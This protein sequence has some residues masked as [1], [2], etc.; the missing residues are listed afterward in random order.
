MKKNYT[1]IPKYPTLVEDMTFVFTEDTTVGEI[2]EIIKKQS[3]L[4]KK[5]EFLDKY[6]NTRTFRITYQHIER[7]LTT[8]DIAPI[9]EKIIKTLKIKNLK[10]K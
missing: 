4:I 7:N 10:L 5:V 3:Q 9:R 8:I 1:P 6:K 2:I